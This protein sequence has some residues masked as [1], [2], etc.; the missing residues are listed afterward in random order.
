[1]ESIA[2]VGEN[3]GNTIG[4]GGCGDMCV[5]SACGDCVGIDIHA[6]AVGGGP[7]VAAECV[8]GWGVNWIG[9]VFDCGGG[10]DAGAE[11]RQEGGGCEGVCA[12]GAGGNWVDNGADAVA[13][14]GGPAVAIGC[15]N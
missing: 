4:K 14:E 6:E 5:E 1:M 12:E 11:R 10:C 9:G 3:G 8:K 13:V 15:G 7:A 2:N